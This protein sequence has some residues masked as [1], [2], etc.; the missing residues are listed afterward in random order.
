VFRLLGS[1]DPRGLK[2]RLPALLDSLR[3]ARS[4]QSFNVAVETEKAYLEAAQRIAATGPR[5]VVFGHTH[6]AKRIELPGGAT[7]LNTG[8]WADLI[9]FPESI[10]EDDETQ[11][12]AALWI[13]V[14]DLEN[15]RLARHIRFNP[16]YVR[17]DVNDDRIERAE[18]CFWPVK[19]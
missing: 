9:P 14:D 13:F 4:N 16:S 17:L 19:G 3:A 15:G 7:Y 5:Y 12:L 8:T 10:F 11:A 6:L 2:A 18:L 1:V